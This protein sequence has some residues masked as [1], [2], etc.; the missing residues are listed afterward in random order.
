MDIKDVYNHIS[1]DFDRT[2]YSVWTGVRRFLDTI[3]PD[4]F[5]GD[6][7][8]GNGKNML[9]RKDI[10]FEGVDISSEFVKI[11]NKKGLCVKEDSILELSIPNNYF[12]NTLCIA[13]IHHLQTLQERQKAISELF[14]ITKPN[15]K[16]LLFVW[17]FEQPEDS[18]RKFHTRDEWVPFKTVDGKVFDRFYHMYGKGELEQEI[19][20]M[21]DTYNFDFTIIESFWEYGNWAIVL[22]KKD[23]F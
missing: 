14:R 23:S 8:C 9:Y 19:K 22:Q 2:R 4:S 5:N 10:S 3:L 6:I 20:S 11:C 16:I 12:D 7:G 15:G 21:R 1:S 17:A 18:K 13:V